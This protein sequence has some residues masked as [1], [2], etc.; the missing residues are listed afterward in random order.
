MRKKI[1]KAKHLAAVSLIFLI[2]PVVFGVENA[3]AQE[4]M[5]P[6]EIVAKHL[7]AIGSAE[8]RA[9]GRSRIASGNSVIALRTGGSGQAGGGASIA[10]KDN[11]IWI[12]A[13]FE[14]P[15]YPF[16]RMSYDGKK[17]VVRQYKPGARS[18]IGE[19]FLT[20]DE[21]FEEG[22][23]GGA[24]SSAWALLRLEERRAKLKYDGT[25]KIDGKPVYRLKYQPR[26]SS[27]L[28]I[29]L[30][31][32]AESFRHVRTEYE[33]TIAAQM[34]A[35]PG[36]SVSQRETHFKLTEDYADFATV[37]GLTLPKKYKISYSYSSRSNPIEIDWTFDFSKFEFNQPINIEKF[38]DEN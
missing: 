11:A 24:L 26:K 5:K 12:N 35:A 21:V 8:A 10:S 22:L 31:F 37:G 15:D 32:D 4:K 20:F 7:E 2:L 3:A 17:L 38:R 9:P 6:D 19:F 23:A 36:T 27:D 16:E 18:P 14:A 29:K 28:K 33:R 13:E 1:E 25:D 30:Y 34:G